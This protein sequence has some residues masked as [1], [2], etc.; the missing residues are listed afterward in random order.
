[1]SW[2]HPKDMGTKEIEVFLTDMINMKYCSINTQRTALDALVYLY[3]RFLG[4]DVGK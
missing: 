1:M 3:K 2:K 4:V